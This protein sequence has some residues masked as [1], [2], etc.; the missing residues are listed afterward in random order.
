MFVHGLGGDR[1]LTWTYVGKTS[2][3]FWPKDLLPK[4]CPEARIMTFGYSS[5]WVRF[6]GLAGPERISQTTI[7]NHSTALLGDL[8]GFR[9]KTK[10]VRP[11]PQRPSKH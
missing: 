3:T 1:E 4:A 11:G 8:A 5:D 6:F 10:T 9:E 2:S 7:K